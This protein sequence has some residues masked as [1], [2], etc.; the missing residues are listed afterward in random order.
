M[1]L[2]KLLLPVV[3]LSIFF[4]IMFEVYSYYFR[5]FYHKNKILSTVISNWILYMS[6][7]SNVITMMLLALILELTQDISKILFLFSFV[8]SFAAFYTYFILYRFRLDIFFIIV[9]KLISF[10]YKVNIDYN[11]HMVRRSKLT[12]KL[13]TTSFLVTVFIFFSL[14]SPAI[15]GYHFFDFRMTLTYSASI[16]NFLASGILLS[17]IEPSFASKVKT[18]LYLEAF[19]NIFFGKLVAIIFI[20]FLSFL[21][22]HILFL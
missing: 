13:P 10:L 22:N 8:Y 7:V 17:Y 9:T 3:S 1:N 14:I 16:F 6:R 21:I 2:Y 18:K 12:W 11:H 4:G 19:Y 5:S 20:V 15:A